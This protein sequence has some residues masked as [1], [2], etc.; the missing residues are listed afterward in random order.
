MC[1]IADEEGYVTFVETNLAPQH[2]TIKVAATWRCHKNAI[3]DV[4]W[5]RGTNF[6]TA[7]GDT[8]AALWDANVPEKHI[9]VFSGHSCSLKS[10]CVSK[11]QPSMFR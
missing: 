6:V 8:T 7:S 2:H 5:S 9:N 1:L 4:A 3:L 11:F 10:I